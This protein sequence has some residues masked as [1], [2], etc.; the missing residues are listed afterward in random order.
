M[1]RRGT[2]TTPLAYVRDCLARGVTGSVQARGERGLW[3]VYLMQGEILAAHG[4]EDGPEILRLLRNADAIAPRQAERLRA[5]LSAGRQL[6]G[7]LLGRVPEDLF[8]ELLAHRF[9]Q[10]LLDFI[11]T[12]GPVEF[13]PLDAVFV[14]NIQTGHE[15]GL[16]LDEL[17]ALAARI[18]P[19]LREAGR[20]RFRVGDRSPPDLA[21]ARLLDRAAGLATVAELLDASPYERGTTASLLLAAEERGALVLQWPGAAPVEPELVVE[22]AEE[23]I[24]AQDLLEL[25]DAELEPLSAAGPAYDEEATEAAPAV[26]PPE[27]EPL[28]DA[29]PMLHAAI[30]QGLAD[31]ERRER[32]AAQVESAEEGSLVRPP[33]F[34]F[35]LPV[36]DELALFDD[37]DQLRGRGEGSFVSE[38]ELLDRV[39]LSDEGMAAFQRALQF[40]TPAAGDDPHEALAMGEASEE[41]AR[42]AV[43]LSFG[44]PRLDEG[45]IQRKF[46]VV[47]DVLSRV[48]DVIDR[49]NGRGSGRVHLQLLVDGPPSRF[50]SLF[51]GVQVDERGRMDTDRLSRNLKKRPE[52][53]HRRLVNEAMLDLIQ[54]VLSTC[55]EELPEE[56]VDEMLERIAGYQQRLGF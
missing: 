9:R 48:V 23:S 24:T 3:S 1:S 10:N 15:S 54:R 12:R 30:Q 33:G 28:A 53:E 34:D 29:D 21:T 56:A 42:A 41:E 2:P 50:G 47:N 44:G 39:D 14:E 19:L 20:L 13:R 38:G 18:E 5:D 32:A 25:E 8:L 51:R 35:D 27:P 22:E 55:L 36:A 40:A 11:Q 49:E 16:L 46:E 4:P 6:E 17:E 26:P 52:T 43:A 31:R 45:D 7:L 37:Q